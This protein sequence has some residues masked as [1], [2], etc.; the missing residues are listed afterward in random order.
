M[1][2]QNLSTPE[3]NVECLE[4][5]YDMLIFTNSDDKK[6]E[7]GEICGLKG[8][9]ENGSVESMADTIRF[10]E[11][12]GGG[13][14][15]L[16]E[17]ILQNCR[18]F[19]RVYDSNYGHLL[20]SR[21]YFIFSQLA[22]KMYKKGKSSEEFVKNL[23]MVAP[24]IKQSVY[25]KCYFFKCFLDHFLEE[26]FVNNSLQK[27]IQKGTLM[28]YIET[29]NQFITQITN[30]VTYDK[31]LAS[32]LDT[33]RHGTFLKLVAKI[34]VLLSYGKL[35][36]FAMFLIKNKIVESH[37]DFIVYFNEFD[38]FKRKVLSM[39]YYLPINEAVA[40]LNINQECSCDSSKDKKDMKYLTTYIMEGII[41]KMYVYDKECPTTTLTPYDKQCFIRRYMEN[42]FIISPNN[43][44]DTNQHPNVYNYVSRS[45]PLV[46]S[47][48]FPQHCCI[49]Y[50]EN[51]DNL[52]EIVLCKH[53]I[54]LSCEMKMK[55]T[56]DTDY[57]KN[58]CPMCRGCIDPSV[59]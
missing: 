36:D 46:S 43:N 34:N 27:L 13:L 22:K 44:K 45:R 4:L 1:K 19:N 41:L 6:K 42:C 16:C 39:Q 30:L 54:C 18:N 21:K 33:V 31:W 25:Y 59:S 28:R 50:D 53:H 9:G 38:N 32:R 40:S 58:R 8:V 15:S 12:G 23:N 24:G 3:S 57:K 56:M 35:Y 29:L 2:L 10:D 48:T 17:R 26:F 20:E 37:M 47:S 52:L 14:K 51:P 55:S 11:S 7:E 5:L 49:C